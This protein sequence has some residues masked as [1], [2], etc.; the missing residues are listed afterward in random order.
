MQNVNFIYAISLQMTKVSVVLRVM[1][2]PHVNMHK[3]G[4]SNQFCQTV[5]QF[6]YAVKNVEISTLQF[7]A[8][9]K[10]IDVQNK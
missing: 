8:I 3:T 9:A 2:L 10:P 7:M 6:V 5:C 4:L 1:I